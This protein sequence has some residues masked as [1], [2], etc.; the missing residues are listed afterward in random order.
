MYECGFCYFDAEKTHRWNHRDPENGYRLR[1]RAPE[2]KIPSDEIVGFFKGVSYQLTPQSLE[3]LDVALIDKRLLKELGESAKGRVESAKRGVDMAALFLDLEGQMLTEATGLKGQILLSQDLLDR[4]LIPTADGGFLAIV[5]QTLPS[6]YK[7][8][9][10][11]TFGDTA[12]RRMR[13]VL[14][15]VP[16]EWESYSSR[17]RL[18]EALEQAAPDEELAIYRE[19]AVELAQQSGDVIACPHC[20]LDLLVCDEC[21]YRERHLCTECGEYCCATC[22]EWPDFGEFSLSK[23]CPSCSAPEEDRNEEVSQLSQSTRELLRQADRL[24]VFCSKPPKGPLFVLERTTPR[25]LVVSDGVHFNYSTRLI[26]EKLKEED[27]FVVGTQFEYTG[28]PADRTR[29][30]PSRYA[31]WER[32]FDVT[33]PGHWE[34]IGSA[35]GPFRAI[36]FNNPLIGYYFHRIHA[37]GTNSKLE[38][39][40]SIHSLADAEPPWTPGRTDNCFW[41][42]EHAREKGAVFDFRD[43]PTAEECMEIPWQKMFASVAEADDYRD[44]YHNPG[45]LY[46]G[47]TF[48]Y[49]VCYERTG[50]ETLGYQHFILERYLL[51]GR[52]TLDKEGTIEV[53][54]PNVLKPTLVDDLGFENQGSFQSGPYGQEFAVELTHYGW[55]G[56]WPMFDRMDPETGPQDGSISD[57]KRYVWRRA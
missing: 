51:A 40:E 49:N 28:W 15:L 53:N 32:S 20:R 30:S 12:D 43:V 44:L 56:S 27:W 4:A 25:I 18:I 26:S 17:R 7:T 22:L 14:A 55:H 36:L 21:A 48:H 9:F 3:A 54:A 19:L 13:F 16:L 41:P 35:F 46:R 45:G 8:D 38:T 2:G 6:K 31:I 34:D 29:P 50:K 24:H 47:R 23:V 42:R 57:M 39:W 52:E 10:R 33:N 1:P 5:E 11:E 37:K